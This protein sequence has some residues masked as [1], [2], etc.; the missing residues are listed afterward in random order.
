MRIGYWRA[1][2][3]PEDVVE[4]IMTMM[5]DGTLEENIIGQR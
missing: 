3:M 1:D 2:A 5:M 4:E